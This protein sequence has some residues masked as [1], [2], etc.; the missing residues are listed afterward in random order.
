MRVGEAIGALLGFLIVAVIVVYS[1]SSS[2]PT[3]KQFAQIRSLAERSDGSYV[4]VLERRVDFEQLPRMASGP[5]SNSP[6]TWFTFRPKRLFWGRPERG[7]SEQHTMILYFD[8][9]LDI[10]GVVQADSPQ[11]P[12]AIKIPTRWFNP[13][14]V[15]T[16][17]ENKDFPV[18][19]IRDGAELINVNDK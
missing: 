17:T 16:T 12:L 15:G 5:L 2:Q 3:I 14:L 9:G 6:S 1:I 19:K 10:G 4:F 7:N 18:L 11:L 8:E 13:I